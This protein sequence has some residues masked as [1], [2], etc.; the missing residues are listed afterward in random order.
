MCIYFY[1]YILFYLLRVYSFIVVAFIYNIHGTTATCQVLHVKWC[2]CF[3]F[4]KFC[5]ARII[6]IVDSKTLKN[7]MNHLFKKQVTHA[8]FW[9]L[10]SNQPCSKGQDVFRSIKNQLHHIRYHRRSPPYANISIPEYLEYDIN[11]KSPM[12][13]LSSI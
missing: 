8:M 10:V 5:T 7:K 12:R 6:Q 9:T 4:W 3:P 1:T 13:G 2:R 11:K